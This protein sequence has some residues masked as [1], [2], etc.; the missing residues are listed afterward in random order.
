MSED[1]EDVLALLT[2][3]NKKVDESKLQDYQP[4]PYQIAF[5]VVCGIIMTLP[6]PIP[7]YN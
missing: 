7:L 6:L 5:H 1:L 3:L 2:A 4:Y